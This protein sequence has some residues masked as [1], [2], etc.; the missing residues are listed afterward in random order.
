MPATTE[1]FASIAVDSGLSAS[2]VNTLS[3]EYTPQI[4]FFFLDCLGRMEIS[5]ITGK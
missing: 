3:G 1:G 2:L 4:R 5:G